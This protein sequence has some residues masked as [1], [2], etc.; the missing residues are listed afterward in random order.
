MN[1]QIDI[2][3]KTLN[4][5]GIIIFPT[6]TAYGIGCRMDNKEAVEKLFKIRKRQKNKPVPILISSIEM[7]EKYLIS[8]PKDVKELMNKFWPGAL[9]IVFPC[10]TGLAHSLIRGGGKTLGVRMPDNKMLL[11][12]IKK[13]GVPILGPS[14]NLSGEETPYKLSEIDKKLI[15]QVDFVLTG[16]TK[17]KKPSTV[18][19]CSKKPWKILREG[20]IKL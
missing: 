18:I 7:A 15:E 14:A 10:K 20:V 4:K 17:H 2:A 16:K 13:I 6:D 11:E 8:I 19:D 5:G 1:K 9:T 12:I 3:I